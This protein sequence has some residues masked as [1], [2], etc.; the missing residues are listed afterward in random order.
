MPGRW[1]RLS[2]D[3]RERVDGGVE[4]RLPPAREI[5]GVNRVVDVASAWRAAAP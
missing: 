2:R 5:R 4:G 1:R 3:E